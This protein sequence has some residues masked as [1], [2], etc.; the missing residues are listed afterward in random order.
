MG[1]WDLR[2]S[3]QKR[4]D[5]LPLHF[6]FSEKQFEEQM[7]SMGLKV[8]DTDKIYKGEFGE[9]YLKT[10]AELINKTYDETTKEMQEALKDDE[11]CID[12]IK[13]ELGNHEYCITHDPSDALEELGL[14]ISDERTKRL[15]KIAKKQYLSSL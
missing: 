9:F 1:Y 3:I 13:S 15:L 6:A 11:F 7:Q 12:A 8:T 4:I 2:T 5:A 10:D 14:N